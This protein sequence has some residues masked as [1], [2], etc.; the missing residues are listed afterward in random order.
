[1]SK[2]LF[3][4]SL[5]LFLFSCDPTRERELRSFLEINRSLEWVAGDLNRSNEDSEH[6]IQSII[7][8]RGNIPK[9]DSIKIIVLKL[10]EAS[11]FLVMS[12]DSV[13]ESLI[14]RT[15]GYK[16][17]E[18][19]KGFSDKIAVEDILSLNDSIIS[20]F[21]TYH[22]LPID[23]IKI[24][25]NSISNELPL[26]IQL[27]NLSCLQWRISKLERSV[28]ERMS[29][30]LDEDD[31]D[32]FNKIK[33]C[34]NPVSTVVK[35]GEP[36]KASIFVTGI[37]SAEMIKEIKFENKSIPIDS[38]GIGKVAFAAKGVKFDKGGFCKKNC[39]GSITITR[40]NGR[41]SVYS[42]THDYKVR[43]KCN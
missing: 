42:F 43:K 15:G 9:D 7:K 38:N 25:L 34:V 13:K 20:F 29:V 39:N 11:V 8:H 21:S 22:S 40:Y 1:M 33:V 12:I 4:I 17:D 28:L 19:I 37:G 23:S 35:E 16:E 2:N 26:S 14:E 32:K 10:R 41:D 30:G 5:C 31:F 6:A 27:M 24:C 36:Y 3:F 18:S